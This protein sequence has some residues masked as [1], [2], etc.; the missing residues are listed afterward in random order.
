[1]INKK[2]ITLLSLLFTIVISFVFLLN[3]NFFQIKE[4]EKN[5]FRPKEDVQPVK[6]YHAAI[7]YINTM[8]GDFITGKIDPAY[9]HK[10]VEQAETLAKSQKTGNLGVNWKEL[11]PDNVGGRTRAILI[12]KD[13]N[14]LMFAGGV[15]G[16]LWKSTT[17]GTYWT[18]IDYKW[19]NLSIVSIAQSTS[20]SIYVGGGEYRI[21]RFPAG[22]AQSGTIG[23]GIYKSTDKGVTW[24]FL[25][26]TK[27][28]NAS[29]DET[30]RWSGVYK[31][32]AHPT[33]SG[34]VYAGTEKGLMITT[35]GGTTWNPVSGPSATFYCTDVKIGSDGNVI[36]FIGGQ[37]YRKKPS[38]TVFTKISSTNV[39]PKG[40]VSRMEFA[41]APSN[42]NYIYCGAAATSLLLENIYQSKDGGETWTVIGPGGSAYLFPYSDA[43]GQ[44]G[45]GDYDN[46]IAVSPAN[47]EKIYVGGVAFWTWENGKGWMMISSTFDS[48]ENEFY[49]HADCHNVIF[50]P[51]N[52]NIMFIAND[53]GIFRSL[54]ALDD[55]PTFIPVFKN[56][57]TTQFYALA[58]KAD[59]SGY[60]GGTQDN[61]TQYINFTGN[62]DKSATEVR[63]GDGGYCEI[64]ALNPLAMFSENPRLSATSAAVYRSPNDGKSFSTFF[65]SNIGTPARE[66]VTPF[67]LWESF[68]DVTSTDSL[69]YV[70]C[71]TCSTINPGDTI[72]V[73]SNTANYPFQYVAAQQIKAKDTIMIK[74]IVQSKFIIGTGDYFTVTP[75]V[76]G[77]VWMTKEALDFSKTP[78]WFKLTPTDVS[79]SY[80]SLAV[81]K[82][83]NV[84]FA[85]TASGSLYRISGINTAV[86]TVDSTLKTSVTGISF[87]LIKSFSRIVNGITVDDN[88][89]NHVIVCLGNYGGTSDF[90]YRSQNALSGTPTFSSIQG[91]LPEMPLYS[92]VIFDD[93][94]YPSGS[95]FKWVVIGTEL[96]IYA[97]NYLPNT[98][99]PDWYEENDGIGK[100]QVFQVRKYNYSPLPWQPWGGL[101]VYAATH[102]RGMFKS[103]TFL[104]GLSEEAPKNNPQV[105][106]NVKLYP[107]PVTNGQFTLTFTLNKS[108]DILIEIFDI[109][110]KK[111][112]YYNPGKVAAGE[113]NIE[114]ATRDLN[115]GTYFLSIKSKGDIILTSKFVVIK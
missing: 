107:N 62:T 76:P 9:F 77:N 80:H 115:K 29:N 69:Q 48:P 83:G 109:Q 100:V 23:A 110:G 98:G 90:I 106:N 82:D 59:G 94:R 6:G 79:T 8:R 27:P 61:G 64:S 87:Q 58:A 10:A 11:G 42:P 73:I 33:D 104:T 65:D 81:S 38:E 7:A 13:D 91:S 93:P 14:N 52:S 2:K 45:Q 71:D 102:G 68:N 74:D 44:Y 111:I 49:V 103:E 50:H 24:E 72:T 30:E 55:E 12:D 78:V 96:G 67:L 88:D 70:H 18:M 47:P 21:A 57:I 4:K 15:A 3:N 22:N 97:T 31:L 101:R 20:G 19:S 41:F 40:S 25:S 113:Q 114:I 35:D 51:Q 46:T 53:G 5:T 56:Y 66:F 108:N 43:N 37:A 92:A 54:N 86:Y 105:L 112:Q 28:T 75:P 60:M 36:A 1:M 89:A 39:F 63:G 85:G 95:G 16:G 84:V 26:A 32:A 99:S 17:G 34:I